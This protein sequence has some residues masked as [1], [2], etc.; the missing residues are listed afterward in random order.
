M[1]VTLWSPVCTQLR[2]QVGHRS[3]P[4]T[5][6]FQSVQIGRERLA[7]ASIEPQMLCGRAALEPES[8]ASG[9]YQHSQRAAIV[10]RG[11]LHG[12]A[13]AGNAVIHLA[14]FDQAIAEIHASTVV[15]RIVCE[16]AAEALGR[17][18]EVAFVLQGDA[19]AD[20]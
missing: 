17:A 12:R 11:G 3:A 19:E 9:A 1:R 4:Y 8:P 20:Q 18:C 14:E 16:H 7:T 6:T 2:Q 15:P 10:V 13:Q 5:T